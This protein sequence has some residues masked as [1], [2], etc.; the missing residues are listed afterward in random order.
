MRHRMAL[1][2]RVLVF[3]GSL[4]VLPIVGFA[5]GNDPHIGVTED[6]LGPLPVSQ[7]L[8]LVQPDSTP[9]I[10]G[11]GD[12]SFIFRNDTDSIIDGFTFDTSFSFTP[13]EG[14]TYTCSSGYFLHCSADLT[15]NNGVYDLDYSFYG[16]DP[17]DGN[18]Y[19]N[20]NPNGPPEGIAP[21]DV[22][23]ISL[24][25][26][27]GNFQNVMLTNTFS[28]PEASSV[29][30]FLTEL[31]LLLGLASLLGLRWNRSWRATVQSGR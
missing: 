23:Y 16:V 2:F 26:W 10:N 20:G 27:N 1:V 8:N 9:C 29:L 19:A 31:L 13:P 12:C 6:G 22:F 25:G 15:S 5:Q 28:V 4:L 30:I 18:G 3:A 17:Y 14:T 11:D 21:G 24:D 7:D